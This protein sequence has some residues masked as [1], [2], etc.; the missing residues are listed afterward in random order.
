MFVFG[1]TFQIACIT[2]TSIRAGM[3]IAKSCH[4][5]SPQVKSYGVIQYL[6][7]HRFVIQNFFFSHLHALLPIAQILSTF[8]KISN[9]EQRL[10]EGQ[11]LLASSGFKETSNQN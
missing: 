10:E 4:T 9:T 11:F 1:V 6:Y 8:I 3:G 5:A 7:L 2:L